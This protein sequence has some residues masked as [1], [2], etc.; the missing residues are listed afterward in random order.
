MTLFERMAAVADKAQQQGAL[1]TIPNQCEVLQAEGIPFVLRYAPQLVEKIRM[2]K[3]PRRENPFAPPEPALWVESVGADHTLIL[4]KFNV[5]PVHGLLITNDF[6]A[7]TDQLTLRDFSAVAQLLT[8]ED[9]LLFYNGGQVAGAS[10]PHRHFQI[11]PKDM[12]LGELPVQVAISQCVHH[13]HGVIY[14]FKHRL[15]WLPDYS[16]ETLWDA[17]LKL[18]YCWQPYNLL[19]TRQWMLVV[20]RS[21]ESTDGISVNSLG[22]AGALL[23]KDERELALIRD[24]GP[25]ELLRRVS[26]TD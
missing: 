23:A 7:Q 18:E 4:N 8:E 16:A 10:Q 14:P 24:V 5:L 22:F 2:G 21:L 6:V 20:P 25:V 11:V 1:T 13:E 12:G 15:Y 9:A 26:V 17:W 19:L 3:S